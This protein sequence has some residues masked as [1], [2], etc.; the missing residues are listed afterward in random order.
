MFAVSRKMPA[1]LVDQVYE[2]L[3]AD[4]RSG[5]YSVDST[6]PS[7]RELAEMLG[8]S[9]LVTRAAVARLAED[10]LVNPRVG[11]GCI[12]TGEAEKRWRG[13]VLAILPGNHGNY[14]ANV[15]LGAL[16]E[17]LSSEGYIVSS[18]ALPERKREG[19]DFS[20][21]DIEL[22][23]RYD[24]VLSIYNKDPI[25]DYLELRGVPYVSV[26]AN[27]GTVKNARGA[28]IVD[29][30]G[31]V[32]KLAEV[33]REKGVRSVLQVSWHKDMADASKP[34]RKAGIKITTVLLKVDY[35][36]GLSHGI[37]AAGFRD[38]MVRDLTPYDLVFFAD[39]NLACGGL[40]AMTNRGIRAPEDIKVVSWANFGQAP[41]YLRDLTRMELNPITG[42]EKVAEA[43]M[44]Y[45]KTQVWEK[46]VAL[47]PTWIDGETI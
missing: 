9:R 38:L 17:R 34:I 29:Y 47:T 30:N 4:I 18:F 39:D 43:V 1:T 20:R 11:S 33:C 19:Y 10:G 16:Q 32:D 44:K 26:M 3:C 40:L 12:V 46:D 8:V 28:V 36:Q 21:L 23:H 22:C 42:G 25:V 6:L 31:L 13:T 2:G 37:E 5:H 35:T 7:T 14:F 24:L 15:M 27:P 41:V 45:L